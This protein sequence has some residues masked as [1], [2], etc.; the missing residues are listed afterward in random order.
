MLRS[1]RTSVPDPAPA[2]EPRV[3]GAGVPPRSL[4]RRF[5]SLVGLIGLVV[6]G[7]T[8]LDRAPRS[9]ELTFD[10]GEAAPE[11]SEVEVRYLHEGEEVAGFRRRADEGFAGRLRHELELSPGRYVVEAVLRPRTGSET[12]HREVERAF[13]VPAEGVITI[14]LRPRAP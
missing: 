4:R 10:L 1:G 2:S 12:A 6:V 14:D 9:V 13:R 7:L 3:V 11:L 8:V 5:A